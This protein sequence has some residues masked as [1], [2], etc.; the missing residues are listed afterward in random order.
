M[1]KILAV[2]LV[3]ISSFTFAKSVVNIPLIISSKQALDFG[4][5]KIIG[6]PAEGESYWVMLV[7][8]KSIKQKDKLNEITVTLLQNDNE[9]IT[10]LVKADNSAHKDYMRSHF[11]ITKDENVILKVQIT[12]GGQ[13]Y[14]IPNI[15]ELKTVSYEE[16]AI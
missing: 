15:M 4:I 11:L 8:P 3:I 2:A 16:F 14:T 13:T 10:T 1:S 9:L 6:K 5:K 7:Y 12:Y